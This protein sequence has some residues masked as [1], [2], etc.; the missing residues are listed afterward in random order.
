[1]RDFESL[2]IWN[3]GMDLAEYA[4]G[5]TSYLPDSEKYGLI[6]Q[7]Q[8]AAIS[9][10]SNIAEGCGR[11]TDSDFGRF[12]DI[13]RGSL[14][15]LNTLTKLAHRIHL[16]PKKLVFPEM[17]ARISELGKMIYG[18]RVKLKTEKSPAPS[19]KLKAQS[20]SHPRMEV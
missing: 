7:I 17:D 20:Q 4:Y 10:P 9:I 14:N 16:Q 6:S 11:N 5:F 15:E 8:R 2:T 3:K 19:S 13:A 12:L 1:M 18:L